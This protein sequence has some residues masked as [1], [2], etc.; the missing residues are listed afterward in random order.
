MKKWILLCWAINLRL[1]INFYC[2]EI[3]N[4]VL[5]NTEGFNL[6]FKIL[7]L[8]QDQKIVIRS[9]LNPYNG[10]RLRIQLN[11]PSNSLCWNVFKEGTFM[12]PEYPSCFLQT[13][14]CCFLLMLSDFDTKYRHVLNIVCE[15]VLFWCSAWYP[16]SIYHVHC[17][18]AF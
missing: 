7:S 15:Y 2:S 18:P 13:N 10:F 9:W 16:D 12:T 6:V 14:A 11:T 5:V 8:S 17:V 3:A 1:G 4:T